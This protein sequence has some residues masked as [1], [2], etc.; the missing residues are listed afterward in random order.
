MT[1]GSLDDFDMLLLADVGDEINVKPTV[2]V[3][4]VKSVNSKLACDMNPVKPT[5]SDDTTC[6]LFHS[7]LFCNATAKG[8]FIVGL[9]HD[10]LQSEPFNG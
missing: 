3:N 6:T 1:G 5:K 2:V 9:T 4:K 7:N 8:D 10:K